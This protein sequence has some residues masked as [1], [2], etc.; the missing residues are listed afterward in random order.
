MQ[1]EINAPKAPNR[2]KTLRENEKV[3]QIMVGINVLGWFV[4]IAALLVFHYARPEFL[5]GVQEFW[6]VTG[7]QEWSSSLSFYLFGLLATC[8][9]I[10]IT[11]LMLKRLRNRREKDHFGINGYVLLFVASASLAILFLEF[12]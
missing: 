11:V 8:V 1:Q 5:S 6:G 2:R 4:F 9:G 12:N 10:S 7:R 3:F